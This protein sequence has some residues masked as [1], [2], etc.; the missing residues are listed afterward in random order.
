MTTDKY[1]DTFVLSRLANCFLEM[2]FCKPPKGS[3]T[4]LHKVK[5]GVKNTNESYK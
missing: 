1:N 2:H 5:E 3:C 4:V